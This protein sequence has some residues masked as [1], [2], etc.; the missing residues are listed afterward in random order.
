MPARPS[1]LITMTDTQNTRLVGAYGDPEV[2]T[3]RL[4][5]LAA[6]GM[7]FERAYTTTPVCT[8]AR[9]GFFTGL[10]PHTAGAWSNL[11][12]LHEGVKTM[13]QRLED[14]GYDTAYAGK[15]HLDGHDYFG[16]G[17]C[18]PGWDASIWYDGRNHLDALTPE[19]RKLWRGGLTSYDALKSHGVKPEFTW[20]HRV[21]DRGI[22]FLRRRRNR[23]FL[24]VVSYDEPHHPFTCPPEYVEPFL[25]RVFPPAASFDEDLADKP[26]HIRNWAEHTGLPGSGGGKI[27]NPLFYGCNSFVDH[28][29][30]RVMDAARE[31]DPD[32]W[33]IHTSDH[34]DML[35][36]HRISNKGPAAYDEIA[37]IPFIV[38]G[39][40]VPS[41][42]RNRSV[43]S[44]VDVLP[45][46]L[47]LAGREVPPV[48]PGRS[49]KPLLATGAFEPA[50]DAFVEYH[51]YEIDHEYFG[52]YQPLRCL[53]RW[54]WKIVVNLL[55][56]DELYNLDTDPGE[57]KN[58]IADPGAAADRDRMHDALLARMD[59]T[60]DPW[61]GSYWANRPWRKQGRSD[62]KGGTRFNPP[63]GYRP[64]FLD[65][66]TGFPPK[67]RFK[68]R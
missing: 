66:D 5:G 34:G 41:G 20:A 12:P 11:I 56:S 51:R 39:P 43:V 45:T 3:P 15:W 35:G 64:A 6:R 57:M 28:E 24:L 52:E 53:V 37:R 19:E 54:P 1:F 7:L 68:P 30:G 14:A 18:P 50:R 49:L 2:R 16:T 21:S 23:P 4:D 48:M 55:T 38:Q 63:D 9:A 61:R 46:L 22:E 32:V 40:G 10:M 33:I 13:G 47:E 59:E 62:W 65:Y 42:S 27:G 58:L 29:I 31:A 60:R 26:E 25:G 36:A 67:E 44:H 17:T 8:P